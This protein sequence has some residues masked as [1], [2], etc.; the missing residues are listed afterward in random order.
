MKD[1]MPYQLTHNFEHIKF[2][3]IVLYFGSVSFKSVMGEMNHEMHQD[4]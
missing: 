2:T 3:E 4:V 1:F